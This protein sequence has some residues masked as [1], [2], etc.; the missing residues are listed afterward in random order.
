MVIDY[1]FG[2]A[3]KSSAE[4]KPAKKKVN[5][6]DEERERRRK[7]MEKLRAEGKV[8][9][10]FGKLG[11]RPRKKRA[12]ELI[13]EEA[14]KNREKIA[15]V[16]KDA[17]DPNQPMAT[18]MKGVQMFIDTEREERRAEIEEEEHLA[19]MGKDELVSH[20]AAR[21]SENP[22]ALQ[23]F[24]DNLNGPKKVEAVDDE[25]IDAEVVD[26]DAA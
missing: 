15:Q 26:D 7:Q 20:M 17:I 11:G 22:L 21:L 8:G 1:A 25:V 3:D 24:L 6:S 9:P 5:I 2:V 23:M 10:Q 4:A 14:E 18:R 19:K 13:A 16:L 12:S